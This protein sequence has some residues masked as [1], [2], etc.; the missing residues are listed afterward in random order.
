MERALSMSGQ[1]VMVD[2]TL[3]HVQLTGS[4][5]V[6][7]P[8]RLVQLTNMGGKL[9]LMSSVPR[10]WQW[11]MLTIHTPLLRLLIHGRPIDKW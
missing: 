10:K 11:L 3:T 2:V 8:S 9:P 4:L 1:L 7:T 6:S 5:P